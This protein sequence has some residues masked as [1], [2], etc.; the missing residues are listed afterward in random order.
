MKRVAIFLSLPQAQTALL[1][2]GAAGIR[3]HLDSSSDALL[4]VTSLAAGGIGL[5][6]ADSQA[7]EAQ[8]LLAELDPSIEL[9]PL[10]S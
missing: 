7:D 8:T 1:H 4:M 3:A 9:I 2:L 10:E 5:W 6:V